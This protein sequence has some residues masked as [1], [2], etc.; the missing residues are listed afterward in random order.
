MSR[1]LPPLAAAA[2]A[3]AS[4]APMPAFDPASGRLAAAPASPL[5][6]AEGARQF[7][8]CRK[9]R[10][11]STDPAHLAQV[12]RVV[13]RLGAVAPPAGG[14]AWEVAVFEDPKPNAFALPGGKIGVYSGLFPITRDD[15]GLAAVLSHEMAHVSL[16]HAQG[17]INR[18][19]AITIGALVLDAVLQTHGV[20]SASRAAAAATW[21][22]G[23]ATGLMLPYSRRAETEADQLGL[24]LMARAGYDPREAVAMWRRF[25]DRRQR[26][27][28]PDSPGFLRTHPL[29]ASRIRALEDYLPVALR[30]YRRR[31]GVPPARR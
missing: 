6:A 12:N 21:G 4:C 24:L 15:A 1:L 16:N 28:K 10:K 11:A 29:D 27:G 18:A 14:Q 19:T 7:N 30:E 9:R 5:L 23:S 17:K 20:A 2:L 3:A 26:A 13:A 22:L 31:P 25:A 8:A